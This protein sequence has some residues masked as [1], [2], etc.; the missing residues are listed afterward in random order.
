MNCPAISPKSTLHNRISRHEVALLKTASPGAMKSQSLILF[1]FIGHKFWNA[2]RTSG[3]TKI[4]LV[5]SGAFCMVM[6][7]KLNL[8]KWPPQGQVQCD[9]LA[10]CL[11]NAI[12]QPS[13]DSRL[14]ITWN[15]S[16]TDSGRTA[17]IGRSTESTA[18]TKGTEGA[19]PQRSF[20]NDLVNLVL[21][22]P[23]G[24]SWK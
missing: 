9:K 13:E 7:L 12:P 20:V 1:P 3:L 6:L 5:F 10:L 2:K 15:Q 4:L 11:A 17:M 14:G 18:S 19:V 8:I 22:H 24:F 23:P 16:S 21:F